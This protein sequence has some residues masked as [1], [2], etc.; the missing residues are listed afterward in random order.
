MPYIYVPYDTSPILLLTL[1][2]FIEKAIIY[3]K[4]PTKRADNIY[5]SLNKNNSGIKKY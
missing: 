5:I 2:G 4:A 1:T 3:T